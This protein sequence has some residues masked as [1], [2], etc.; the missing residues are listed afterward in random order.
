MN[1][2][3]LVRNMNQRVIGGVAAG[4]A[5]FF[6]LDVVLV[7]VLFVLAI[8]IPV[9]THVIFLYIILW[10]V[11]PKGVPSL[12]EYHSESHTRS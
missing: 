4:L 7:R 12:P 3:K 11:M 8:F 6:E 5:D 1:N 2:R 10:A 9:P